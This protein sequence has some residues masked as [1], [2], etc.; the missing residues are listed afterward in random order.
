MKQNSGSCEVITLTKIML[1]RKERKRMFK[2][3]NLKA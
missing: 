3:E 1:K 2:R